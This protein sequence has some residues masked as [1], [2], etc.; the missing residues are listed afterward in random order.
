MSISNINVFIKLIVLTL[1]QK[2]IS[3]FKC[4]HPPYREWKTG[5]C[6]N[7]LVESNLLPR[8]YM[9]STQCVLLPNYHVNAAH[10][11]LSWLIIRHAET[12]G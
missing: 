7:M 9:S 4:V 11:I 8:K 5:I 6:Q 12:L 10:A 3:G 1:K 2:V